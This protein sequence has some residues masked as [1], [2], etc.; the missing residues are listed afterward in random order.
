LRRNPT[1]LDEVLLELLRHAVRGA[2]GIRLHVGRERLAEHARASG[3]GSREDRDSHRSSESIQDESLLL[4]GAP[5][6]RRP[7][8]KKPSACIRAH[9]EPA[10]PDRI[11]AE[12]AALRTRRDCAA[13]D[14]IFV[15]A[16][17][18]ELK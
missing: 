3:R 9:L 5:P 10:L 13:G 16:D 12:S 8:Y 1:L 17:R 11:T 2:L 14:R 4:A 15:L 7:L 18:L 6:L